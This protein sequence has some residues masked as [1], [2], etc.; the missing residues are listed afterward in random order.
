MACARYF[1]GLTVVAAW[2]ESEAAAP[3][4][5]RPPSRR[6]CGIGALGLICPSGGLGETW[7]IRETWASSRAK[8]RCTEVSGFDSEGSASLLTEVFSAVI[9]RASPERAML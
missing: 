9:L 1:S 8:P 2:P 5:R 6:Q 3:Q 4:L 7:R